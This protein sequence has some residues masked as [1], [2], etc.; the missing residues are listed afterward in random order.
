MP[1]RFECR[2]LMKTLVSCSW[3]GFDAPDPEWS[4]LPA[5]EPD[6]APG[7]EAAERPGHELRTGEARGLR[8]RARLRLPDGSH[9][10]GKYKI[11]V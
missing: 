11:A 9:L 6:R 8:T 10:R 5:L 2:E 4:G 3:T 7:P 1:C